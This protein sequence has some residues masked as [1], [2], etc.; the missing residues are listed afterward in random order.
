MLVA[1]CPICE[2]TPE[3]IDSEDNDSSDED[4]VS[5]PRP[6]DSDSKTSGPEVQS[7]SNPFLDGGVA[8]SNWLPKS[9]FTLN[10]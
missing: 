3:K 7:I 2:R 5:E 10:T 6:R 8:F 1:Q 9:F 4:S